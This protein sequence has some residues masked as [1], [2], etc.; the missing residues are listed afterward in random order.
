MNRG[1]AL[2]YNNLRDG[3]RGTVNYPSERGK[4]GKDV[5]GYTVIGPFRGLQ[6][7]GKREPFLCNM[8]W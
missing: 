8:N 6:E 3:S 7:R 5:G 2:D 1:T 4:E